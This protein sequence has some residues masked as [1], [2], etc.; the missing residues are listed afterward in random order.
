LNSDWPL[1]AAF[2]SWLW[3]GWVLSSHGAVGAKRVVLALDEEVDDVLDAELA[4]AF[5]SV[6]DPPKKDWY[7]PSSTLLLMLPMLPATRLC[8]AAQSGIPQQG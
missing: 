1:I 2:T 3:V 4:A 5:G 7:H 6:P 8:L